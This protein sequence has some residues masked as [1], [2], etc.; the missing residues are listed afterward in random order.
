MKT[1]QC[2]IV[3]E[4]KFVQYNENSRN[5]CNDDEKHPFNNSTD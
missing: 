3:E 4:V 2:K 1:G 5:G